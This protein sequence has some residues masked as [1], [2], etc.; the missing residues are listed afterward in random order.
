MKPLY[1][2]PNGFIF[3]VTGG[4]ACGKS[5]ACRVWE[6]A[7]VAI[8]DTDQLGHDILLPGA[9]AYDD[10]VAAFG[11]GILGD[12]QHINRKALAAIVFSD[13][14]A[15]ERLNALT[16]P[17]IRERWRTWRDTQRESRHVAAVMIPLLFER[18]LQ[19]EGWD[20]VVAV[21]ADKALVME[22]LSKRGLDAEQAA[23]RIQSQWPNEEKARRA[24]FVITNNG[25]L[26]ALES[27]CLQ[28]LEKMRTPGAR[29]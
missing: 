11:L 15:L 12:H 28:C 7:G 5:E 8:L 22:R 23:R 18:G 27:Q 19:D 4:I 16:H 1:Q 14:V 3:C 10:V 26:E 20:A 6:R 29:S 21:V 2:P 13:P 25:T 17:H 24:D 9:A